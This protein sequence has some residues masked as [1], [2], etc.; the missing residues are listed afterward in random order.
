MKKLLLFIAVVTLGLATSC[1]KD[2]DNIDPRDKYVGTWQSSTIGSLTLYQHGQSIGTVPIDETGTS[3]IS[4]S[5]ENSLNIG[6]II[7]TVN[8]NSLTANPESITQ[9][10][11]GVNIVGTV[12]YS[13][14]LSPEI[15][16]INSDITGSW[17]NNQ[18]AS[19]NLS[20]TIIILLTK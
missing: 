10:Q 5:G 17:S 13:G 12:I 6:G 7:F 8:G 4:K 15:I 3:N 18:G 11:D 19:G 14:Q 9:T 20:G 2:D 16:T 1:S